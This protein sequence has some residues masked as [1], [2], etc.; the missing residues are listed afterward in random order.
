MIGLTV[1]NFVSAAVGIAVA[2]VLIRGLIRRRSSTV[3][4][5]WVDLV[6]TVTRILLPISIVAR[7]DPHLGRASSRTSPRRSP[8]HTL[9]GGHQTL[10]SGALGSQEAIKD[11]GTNGGGPTNA[12]SAHP[13]ENPTGFTNLFEIWLLLVIPFALPWT[14]GKLCKDRR[15]GS[16]IL[17]A[18]AV[19]WIV[20]AVAVMGF[21]AARQ[22][23]PPPWG[24]PDRVGD[25]RGRQSRGQGD[26]LR[27]R[28]LGAL[29]R[30]DHGRR[31]PARST[32]PTTASRRS[33]A[34]S[35]LTNMM[36]GE[37][38]PGGVGSGLY[39]MLIL[40]MLSVFIAGL[41]VGR[42]P[43]YLGKKIQAAEMKL[44]AIYILIVP[45]IGP[46]VRRRL[47]RHRRAARRRSLQP[48]PARADRDGLRVRRRRP[49]T[50]ARRSPGFSGNT[51]GST[52]RS[53]IACSSAASP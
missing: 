49:T 29:R 9:A 35:S 31:R 53:A 21:E 30:V 4:S 50:T 33:A 25:R 44:V 16:A 51:P 15:Q 12:N 39:G 46:R 3:G 32:R 37:V 11:L 6:R 17:G 40:A 48:G 52:R 1:Q 36:F 26:P 45:A 20:G 47:D 42:T 19:L 5:F 14:F 18:M 7:A 38:S 23:E 43:E 27:R 10:T 34:G 24:Q 8:S 28:R 2:V 22:R 41:M 13:F